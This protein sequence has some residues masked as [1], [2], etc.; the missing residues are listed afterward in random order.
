VARDE[1]GRGGVLTP[2]AVRIDSFSG[3]TA[4]LHARLVHGLGSMLCGAVPGEWGV[5]LAA[6]S[7]SEMGR[8]FSADDH[9]TVQLSSGGRFA[10]PLFD[11][12]CCRLLFG[13]KRS[14][15][16]VAESL[17]ELARSGPVDFLDGGANRG[18]WSCFA[19][20]IA[21]RVVAVEAAPH[22]LPGL[23]ANARRQER[24]FEVIG[25]ALWSEDGIELPMKSHPR[26]HPGGGVDGLAPHEQARDGGRWFSFRA[27]SRTIDSLVNELG[28]GKECPLVVKL[29][30]E[31]SEPFAFRGAAATIADGRTAFVYE[32]HASDST[33]ASTRAALDA[34]LEIFAFEGDAL[35]AVRDLA[36]VAHRKRRLRAS[37]VDLVALSPHGPA[38]ERLSDLFE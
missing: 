18:L 27:R 2:P 36:G 35:R 37:G 4:P 25:A 21:R 17:L 14:S 16:P 19:S 31:G 6:R 5:R 1:E 7:M 11:G 10:F 30:I 33:H 3:P 12:F 15:H 8:A 28:L 29:D 13:E 24:S 22:L 9:V 32:D 20:P 38:R 23:L 34:G 26:L